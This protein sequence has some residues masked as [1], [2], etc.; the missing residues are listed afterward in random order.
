LGWSARYRDVEDA[1]LVHIDDEEREDW[2]KPDVT[3]CRKSQA[4][5][6]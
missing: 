2:T 5:T 6:L 1:L 3:D 4:Q